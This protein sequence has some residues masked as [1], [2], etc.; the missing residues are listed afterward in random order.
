MKGAHG[1]CIETELEF[2]VFM[3]GDEKQRTHRKTPESRQEPNP[4]RFNPFMTAG[5]GHNSGG[6]GT[7]ITLPFLFSYRTVQIKLL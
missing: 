7:L 2:G 1:I 5:P 4:T 6:M 3:W